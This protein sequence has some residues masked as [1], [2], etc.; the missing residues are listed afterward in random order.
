MILLD[1]LGEL[2][3]FYGI[4]DVVFVGGSLVPHGGHNLVEPAVLSRPILSGPHLQNFQAISEALLN[5]GGM[6]VVRS[7]QELEKA[8]ARLLQDPAQGR[9][10]GR[11]ARAVI[12]QHRGAAARTADLIELRW[13][14]AL[15]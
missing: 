10:M 3:S 1:T 11:R 15:G 2:T 6:A 13:G 4:S 9:E 8:L 14:K 7:S 5:A 12:D